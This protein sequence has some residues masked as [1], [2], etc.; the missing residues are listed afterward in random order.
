MSELVRR[1]QDRGVAVIEIDNPPVNALSPGVPEAL[2]SALDAAA[3]DPEI[4]AVV[5]R[6]AGRT[7]IAGADISTLE[8]AAWGDLTALPDLHDL[9]ARIENFPKPVVMAIHGTALGGGLELAMAGHFR[10]AAADALLGQPEVNLGIIPGAEGTQRLPRLVGVERALTMCVTGKPVKAPDALAAG[11]IDE[12]VHGDLTAG[13][14]TFA[15]AAAER[16]PVAKTR[17]RNDRLGSAEVN[18]PLFAA[19]RETAARTRRHQIAPLK[20]VDAI[21][22]AATLPFDAGCRRE[23]ELFVECVQSEQAKALVHVFFAERAVTRVPGVGKD[24]PA[25]PVNRVA[26]VGAGTMG[27]GIAMACVNAGMSVVLKETSAPALDTG[28]ATIRKNYEVSVKRGRFTPAQVDERLARIQPQLG[29]DGFETADLVIEAVFESL[30]LKR[31]IFAELDGVTKRDAV[32]GTNT[33]TLDIDLIAN[34]TSRP[35][36]VIGLHFFS[37]ANVMRLLEIV[38]G[39]ETSPAA[40]ATAF[41][42]ARRL[43]KVGVLAGNCPGFI[44]NRMMF[45]YMYETQFLVEEGATPEQV[46]RA[47]TGF[48]MAMGMFAVDDMAGIDVAWRVRQEFPRSAGSRQPLV[49]DK[50]YELGRL[51]QKTGKGWY[52]YDEARRPIPD[53]DVV[54]LIRSLAAAARIP[55][56]SFSDDEIVQRSILALVNE[57]ARVLDE[58]FALRAS[59]I[60][61]IYV[62]GY[63]FPGWRGGPMF[64]ADRLGLGA[65]LERIKTFHRELGPRWAPAPLLVKLAAQG[66]TF[67]G[68]D[69]T[70]QG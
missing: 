47:L 27:G 54:D 64:H 70:R 14:V 65:V 52:R 42:L 31:R 25:A 45:P 57:G 61:V 62:N 12:I 15:S 30:D 35:A 67:R 9:L 44:G 53:P 21:E 37:P 36:S 56:R 48:G 20:A 41:A 68:V 11:L 43:G 17:D 32:L 24:T 55:Q 19:A 66:G 2:A 33:S 1:H 29:Y 6:G 51:G 18:A 22:A 40:I 63:G 4:A 34:A 39:R 28:L 38:R 23:R 13:A 3:A 16:S 46:D 10:V 8:H 7:F 58:G 26:I 59:D 69:R 60:D 50:L 49:A 5:I